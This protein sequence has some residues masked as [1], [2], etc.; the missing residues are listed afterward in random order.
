MT[1]PLPIGYGTQLVTRT[2][3]EEN[4]IGLVDDFVKYVDV[5]S[6]A[7]HSSFWQRQVLSRVKQTTC[8]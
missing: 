3:H 4:D 5:I 8:C 1:P 2:E 7:V 6:A